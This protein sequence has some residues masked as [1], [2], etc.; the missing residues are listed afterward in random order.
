[1]IKNEFDKWRV[2]WFEG[3]RKQFKYYKDDVKAI[4][5]H[6][7]NLKTYGSFLSGAGLAFRIKGYASFAPVGGCDCLLGLT[8]RVSFLGKPREYWE[9]LIQDGKK[10][11]VDGEESQCT[12]QT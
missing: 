10:M 9:K 1:L 4:N 12:N 6:I 8:H 5:H 11:I 7:K 2:T 3:N